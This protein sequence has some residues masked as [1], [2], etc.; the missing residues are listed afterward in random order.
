MGRSQNSFIKKEKEKERQRKKQ[1]KL[2]R[3]EERKLQAEEKGTDLEDMIAYVDEFGNITDKLPDPVKK[4]EIK[5]SNIEISVPK[6]DSEDERLT[7]K[8]HFYDENRGFGFIHKNGSQ[9][10]FFFHNSNQEGEALKEGDKVSFKAARGMKGM[11]AIDIK[12]LSD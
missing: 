7:G 8:V 2:K 6:K 9:D 5:A 12:I 3:K 11:D 1:E 4:S 10:S